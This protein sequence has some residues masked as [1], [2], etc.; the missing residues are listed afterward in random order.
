M[1]SFCPSPCV[2]RQTIHVPFQDPNL[3]FMDVLAIGILM[4]IIGL[5]QTVPPNPS[6][7][8]VCSYIGAKIHTQLSTRGCYKVRNLRPVGVCMTFLIA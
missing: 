8:S 3:T 5:V 2:Q 1:F 4:M 6:I 7:T